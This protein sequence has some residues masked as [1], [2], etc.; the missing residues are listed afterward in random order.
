MKLFIRI[1]ISLLGLAVVYGGLNY[2]ASERVEVV[3][4]HTVDTD[5]TP[6]DTR[7]WIVD[8]NGSAYIRA[9]ETS[10]WYARV[11]AMPNIE[12]SRGSQRIRYT[13][14]PHPELRD[15]LNSRFR[16]KYG[17]GDAF[18]SFTIGGRSDAI[19]LELVPMR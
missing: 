7:I 17:W 9:R 14:V 11:R 16:N 4:L 18:V 5:A 19:P 3:T 8:R 15:E 2:L 10:R 13:V 1:I 6:R 12:L